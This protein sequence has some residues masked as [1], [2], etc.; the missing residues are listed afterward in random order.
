[1][2][3]CKL[4]DLFYIKQGFAFKSEKY[5]SQSPYVLCTLGNFSESNNFKFNPDKA[6]Y[7][8]DEFSHDFILQENDLIMPLTEQVVGLFGNTAFVP[9]TKDFQFVLNQRVGKIIPYSEKADKIF[10]H[11]LLSTELVR[12][13]IEATASGTKQRNT[14]PDKIYDVTVWVPNVTA[15]RIIG[16]RLYALEQKINNNIRICSEL[17]SM[18]KM[19][20]DYWFV[21]FDFPDENGKPYRT[22][23]GEMVWNDQLKREIPK[24]W[25]VKPL[26]YGI[27]SI[28]TGL[29]PRDNFSLGKGNIQYVTVKNLTTAGTI[30]FSGCDTLDEEAKSMVHTRSDI[31]I[32]DILFASIAP[33]GRCY[34]IQSTP[35]NWDINE[36]VFSI[37]ANPEVVTSEFLYMYFMSNVFIKGATS[38]STGS[39]FKGIRINTLLDIVAIFPPK[40]VVDAFTSKVKTLLELKEEKAEE[41]RELTKLRDWLLPMLMNGQATV[42]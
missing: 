33:L 7:Y 23:G 40:H 38:S 36:S 21:Q 11:Y 2:N 22:S 8:P 18:A 31:S 4:G 3:K 9:K 12:N 34:L 14:S 5:V 30:D 41:N 28:N 17:E 37:R 25:K 39:I 15:Q 26:S 35:K 1:M 10:L 13:Q 16:Q 27:K 6:T 29:N 19:L 32:G 20:Y 24:G 42:K